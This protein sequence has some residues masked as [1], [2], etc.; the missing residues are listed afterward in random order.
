MQIFAN[1]IE[2]VGHTPLVKL[3]RLA[4]PQ[5]TVLAKVEGRNAAYSIKDRVGVAMLRD[6]EERGILS[7]GVTIVEPTSGNTG[8]ALAFA[9]AVK[10]YS[11]ILTM[12]ETMSIERRKVLAMLGAKL[13]LTKGKEGMAGAIR[14]AEELAAKN[15]AA[16]FIP[17][18]FKNPANPKAH[19]CGTG[20]ELWDATEGRIDVLVAGVGTGGTLTGIS[21]YWKHTRGQSLI[22]VAVEPAGSPVISQTLA[23][24]PVHPG[25]HGIQGIGAG[26]IPETLDLN[27]IDR[28]ETVENEE[29]I[30]FSRRLAKEEGL[31]AGISSGA[32]AAVA[33][34]LAAQAEFAGKVIACILP[35]AGERYVSSAL[36]AGL[37]E[38]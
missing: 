31:L 37:G 23:G 32:A 30:T 19:E 18:Q 14:A 29:A 3:S 10:G 9:S 17:Q 1:T 16:Y 2:T 15:P 35:D 21:R 5:A 26:F 20:P 36:F 33:C 25:P 8:I 34:R 28:V 22:S 24:K 12:P 13:V 4:K 6:A 27:I 7:P 11:C 38:E